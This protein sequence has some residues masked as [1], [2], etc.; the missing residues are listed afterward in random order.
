[1]DGSRQNSEHA[2]GEQRQDGRRQRAGEHDDRI[3]HRE[4][5]EDVIA[6]TAGANRRRDGCRPDTDDR[7]HTDTRQD[8]RRRQ[9]QLDEAEDLAR[10]HAHRHGALE[11][12]A[13]D[14][15]ASPAIVVRTIGSTA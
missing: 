10:R 8:G 2:V 14:R 1:M 13:I 3:D 4:A 11:D 12:G 15:P 6:K 7:R 9:R 5:A